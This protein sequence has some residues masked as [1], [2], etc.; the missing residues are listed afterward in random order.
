MTAC[1]LNDFSVLFLD[2]ELWGRALSPGLCKESLGV[3]KGV[4]DCFLQ[5]KLTRDTLHNSH[6]IEIK[7][8]FLSPRFYL[9]PLE[10]TDLTISSERKGGRRDHPFSFC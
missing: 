4:F 7:T 8:T 3:M 5:E 10:N 1:F 9:E 2:C 6:A